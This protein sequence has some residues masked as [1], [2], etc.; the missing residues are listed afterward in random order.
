MWITVSLEMVN[1]QEV[2]TREHPL[3]NFW[4]PERGCGWVIENISLGI[5]ETILHPG[6]AGKPER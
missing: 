5:R 2:V 1:K 4:S 6:Q 3:P